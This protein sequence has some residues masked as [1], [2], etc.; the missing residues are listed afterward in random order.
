MT[1]VLAEPN[2]IPS[3]KEI[4]SVPDTVLD[5]F[6]YGVVLA[7]LALTYVILHLIFSKTNQKYRD[8]RE[9]RRQER[10]GGGFDA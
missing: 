10:L 8:E 7:V 1:S 6:I 9:Q 4:K 5:V 2:K 3:S